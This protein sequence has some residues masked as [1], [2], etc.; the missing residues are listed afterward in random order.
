MIEKVS[1]IWNIPVILRISRTRELSLMI[2]RE[3]FNVISKKLGHFPFFI[4]LLII[5]WQTLEL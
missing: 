1:N 4:M 5:H 3:V 2:L